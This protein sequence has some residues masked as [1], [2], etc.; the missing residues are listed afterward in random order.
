MQK[1]KSVGSADDTDSPCHV[2]LRY[3]KRNVKDAERL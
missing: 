3:G 1:C 2:P